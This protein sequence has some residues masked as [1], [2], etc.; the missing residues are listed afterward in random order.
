M[1]AEGLAMTEVMT[2]SDEQPKRGNR[3]ARD[4]VLVS[5]TSWRCIS[6]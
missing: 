4:A 5:G 1:A 6:A 2:M 3:A